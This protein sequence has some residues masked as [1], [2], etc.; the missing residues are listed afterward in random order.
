[1]DALP[2]LE[3]EEDIATFDPGSSG[4]IK[5]H[6]KNRCGVSPCEPDAEGSSVLQLQRIP[7]TKD[8]DRHP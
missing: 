6:I 7:R 8:I 3:G 1:M 5:G 2:M 4:L